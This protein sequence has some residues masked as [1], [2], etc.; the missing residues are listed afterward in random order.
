MWQ[1]TGLAIVLQDNKILKLKGLLQAGDSPE[2]CRSYNCS[3]IANIS[4][5]VLNVY[6]EIGSV[7]VLHKLRRLGGNRSLSSYLLQTNFRKSQRPFFGT[8]V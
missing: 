7:R 5:S 2:D 6:E 3:N 4:T 1:H 8:V